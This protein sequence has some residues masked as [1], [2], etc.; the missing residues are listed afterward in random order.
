MGDVLKPGLINAG[1]ENQTGNLTSGSQ[2][3][4]VSSAQQQQHQPSSGKVLTGDL[5]SSLAS[6]AENLTINKSASSQVK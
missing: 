5:D 3:T 2:I 6:L 1:E 4:G